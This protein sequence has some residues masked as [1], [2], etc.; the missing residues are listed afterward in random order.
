[1]LCATRMTFGD[2]VVLHRRVTRAATCWACASMLPKRGSRSM[3]KR[4]ATPRA[5]RDRSMGAHTPELAPYP[6]RNRTGGCDVALTCP[7]RCRVKRRAKGIS[8]NMAMRK[9]PVSAATMAIARG[10][11]RRSSRG[12]GV[13]QSH[14]AANESGAIAARA[15]RIRVTSDAAAAPIGMPNRWIFQ[16]IAHSRE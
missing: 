13:P 8:K 3:V 11:R 5:D 15:A 10:H 1:M 4:L 7:R 9:A 6:W 2:R 14:A 12:R 16:R